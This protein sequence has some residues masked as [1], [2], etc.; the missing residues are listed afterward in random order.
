MKRKA[1]FEQVIETLESLDDIRDA[2]GSLK[3]PANPLHVRVI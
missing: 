3:T 2:S 1:A